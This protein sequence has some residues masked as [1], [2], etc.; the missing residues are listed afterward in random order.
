[1]FGRRGNFEEAKQLFRQYV[2][3]VF[4][5]KSSLNANFSKKPT[6][7]ALISLAGK[8]NLTFML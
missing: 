8:L 3:G 7:K 1:M 6:K 5:G 2:S 4:M